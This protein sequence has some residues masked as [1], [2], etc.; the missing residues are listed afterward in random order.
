LGKGKD[1]WDR[2][3][4]EEKREEWQREKEKEIAERTKAIREQVRRRRK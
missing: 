4:E 3:W 1:E 2:M